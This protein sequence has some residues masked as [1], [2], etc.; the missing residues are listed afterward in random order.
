MRCFQQLSF[1]L[2]TALAITLAAFCGCDL[3]TYSK[4]SSDYLEANPGGV[5]KEVK[6]KAE[7]PEKTSA[8]NMR[9]TQLSRQV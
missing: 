6:K 7:E 2:T 3:G 8:V 4:R 1:C 5:K 9:G